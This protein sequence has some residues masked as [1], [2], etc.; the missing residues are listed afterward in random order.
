MAVTKSSWLPGLDPTHIVLGGK[1][2]KALSRRPRQLSRSRPWFPIL[3]SPASPGMSREPPEGFPAVSSGWMVRVADGSGSERRSGGID[4]LRTPASSGLVPPASR[5]RPYSRS[6][7][8]WLLQAIVAAAT[9]AVICIVSFYL[10]ERDQMRR[11]AIET[12]EVTRDDVRDAR[13]KLKERAENAADEACAR[14]A[15][16]YDTWDDY[17]DKQTRRKLKT[18]MAKCST[19]EGAAAAAPP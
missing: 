15:E 1:S 2:C 3:L 10:I 7:A 11:E 6:A 13:K 5:A 17:L 18:L 12:I 19:G 9:V 16:D 4:W 14:L 8:V